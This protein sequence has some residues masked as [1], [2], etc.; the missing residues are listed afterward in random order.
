MPIEVFVPES[1]LVQRLLSVCES[2][3]PFV[4][5]GHRVRNQADELLAN[6]QQLSA[7]MNSIFWASL[8]LEEGRPVV[9]S[10]CICSPEE[11]PRSRKLLAPA[12]ISAKSLVHLLVASPLNSLAVHLDGGSP[13]AWGF[14]DSRPMFTVHLRIV[15]SGTLVASYDSQ[16]IGVLEKGEVI[17]PDQIG[18]HSFVGL[19]A[20]A[21]DTEA[22]PQ[23]L[24]LAARIQAVVVA[25]HRHGHGGALVVTPTNGA[26]ADIAD[27]AIG[28]RFDPTA[29]ESIRAA[30]G[31]IT[32]AED[33][34]AESEV[35]PGS[36]TQYTQLPALLKS[37]VD[38][39]RHL[40]DRLL[41]STGDLSRIDGAIV[42][43][44]SL[45]VHGFG[46]KLAGTQDE[47]LVNTLDVLTKTVT[48]VPVAALGGM[49]HQSAAR[50]IHRNHDSM[51]IVASQDGR[52]T[53]FAWA[54]S[55]GEVV[56][57]GR[58]EY[59]VWAATDTF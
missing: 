34:L 53:L 54:R 3:K 32:A 12:P 51:V 50:Y 48:K 5:D 19:I 35:Q 2:R 1:P 24:A 14:L 10:V 42:M 36:S 21:L 47:F 56:A 11:S 4:R 38:A 43:D 33:R 17:L 45:R 49:R 27:I 18:K 39:H 59:G 13:C 31:E 15:A 55:P 58:L 40:L 46:A 25:M 26:C 8:H 30:L 37:S 28:S 16:V 44:E 23:R 9:G 6:A 20:D 52:V 29:T 57:I 7:L 22:F 41:V